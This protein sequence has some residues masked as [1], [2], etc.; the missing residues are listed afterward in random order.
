M[1]YSNL[2]HPLK[3]SA[4]SVS[5]SLYGLPTVADGQFSDWETRR[6]E[7]TVLLKLPK[8]NLISTVA[9]RNKATS[10][11][12]VKIGMDARRLREFVTVVDERRLPHDRRM[13][14]RLGHLPARFVLLV[15]HRGSPIGFES[16]SCSGI[17]LS[18]LRRRGGQPDLAPMLYDATAALLF[19]NAT[20]PGPE[21]APSVRRDSCVSSPPRVPPSPPPPSP[22]PPQ[23]Q[24]QPGAGRRSAIPVVD[25]GDEDRSAS[26]FRRP[27]SPRVPLPARSAGAAFDLDREVLRADQGTGGAAA[28]PRRSPQL[29]SSGSLQQTWGGLIHAAD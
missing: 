29:P 25:G 8:H 9:F 17:A 10:V 3:F 11:L 12:T 13:V 2:E 7:A 26:A 4:C 27:F 14:L 20:P 16:V 1:P 21:C 22:P 15:C 18:A 28:Q 19:G 23:Q 24:Q 6:S 5:S